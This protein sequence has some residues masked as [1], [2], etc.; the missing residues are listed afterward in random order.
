MIGLDSLLVIYKQLAP[1]KLVL[2]K[3]RKKERSTANAMPTDC[4]V[5][6]Q[7]ITNYQESLLIPQ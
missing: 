3:E 4:V 2:L 1:P 7:A 6:H 5:T